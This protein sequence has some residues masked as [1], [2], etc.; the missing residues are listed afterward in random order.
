MHLNNYRFL[1]H[2]NVELVKYNKL[3]SLRYF[4]KNIL[5]SSNLDKKLYI[6]LEPIN[7]H[8]CHDIIIKVFKNEFSIYRFFVSISDNKITTNFYNLLYILVNKNKIN[9]ENIKLFEFLTTLYN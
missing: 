6:E 5:E 8:D 7:S 4:F 3:Y 1:S 9:K 2:E